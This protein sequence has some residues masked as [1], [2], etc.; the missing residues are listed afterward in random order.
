MIENYTER[1]KKLSVQKE[2]YSLIPNKTTFIGLCGPNPIEYLEKIDY[3]RFV[4]VIFYETNLKIY[5]SIIEQLGSDYPSVKVY[6]K[7][8]NSKLGRTKAFYDLDY[9]RTLNDVRIHLDK[10]SKIAD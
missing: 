10:I 1:A 2:I 7:S 9:C 3:R 4:N 8:I 6:N 5:N